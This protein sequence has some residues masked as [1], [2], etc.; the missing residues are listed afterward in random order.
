MAAWMEIRCREIFTSRRED[1]GIWNLENIWITRVSFASARPH[2]AL[3]NCSRK[4]PSVKAD[5]TPSIQFLET[6]TVP[7]AL[8][9]RCW[10]GSQRTTQLSDM[11][12]AT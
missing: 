3:Q 9:S 2:I 7:W 10:I 4:E 12:I 11:L 8:L 1:M 5:T 6:W